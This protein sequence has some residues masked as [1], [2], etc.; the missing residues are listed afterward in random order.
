MTAV[1]AY[2]RAYYLAHREQAIERAGQWR[3]DNPEKLAAQRKRFRDSGRQAEWSR[4][5]SLTHKDK[6]QAAARQRRYGLTAAQYN[7]MILLQGGV[8]V[9]CCKGFGTATPEVDHCHETGK[10]RALI[11]KK[12]NA[13]CVGA[14]TTE[15]AKRVLAL[16]ESDFD[17]RSL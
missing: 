11:H 16:L 2:R 7:R 10:V 8:C 14:N 12:C 1:Q 9:I 15:T 5:H 4:K 6:R 3:K 13:A 17:G